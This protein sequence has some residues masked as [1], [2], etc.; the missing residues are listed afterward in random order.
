MSAVHR[1][2]HMGEALSLDSLAPVTERRIEVCRWCRR[3][4]DDVGER[5]SCRPAES[6]LV[7]DPTRAELCAVIADLR[8]ALT[9]IRDGEGAPTRVWKIANTAL[10]DAE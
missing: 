2:G 8:K 4:Y 3:P 9:E 5:C 6:I 1:L 7:P 10:G